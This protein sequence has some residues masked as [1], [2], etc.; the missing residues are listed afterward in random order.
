MILKDKVIHVIIEREPEV[1]YYG[2]EDTPIPRAKIKRW[3]E[4]GDRVDILQVWR[5]DIDFS[6]PSTHGN[7][8]SRPRYVDKRAPPI[9]SFSGGEVVRP[10]PLVLGYVPD[11]KEALELEDVTWDFE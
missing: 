6:Y 9:V 5:R 7:V 8:D 10:L 11:G 4:R 2:G 1:Y 3:I